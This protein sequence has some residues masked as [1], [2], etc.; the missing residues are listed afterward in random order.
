MII[1]NKT[2]NELA[3]GLLT[4]WTN[5]PRIVTS[6]VYNNSVAFS[7]FLNTTVINKVNNIFF[8]SL[9]RLLTSIEVI[10]DFVST[11]ALQIKNSVSK[12]FFETP[13]KDLCAIY[14]KAHGQTKEELRIVYNLK[15]IVKLDPSKGTL[16][17]RIKD[18]NVDELLEIRDQKNTLPAPL[19]PKA[20]ENPINSARVK[21]FS[22]KENSAKGLSELE[23]FLK[24]SRN[25]TLHQMPKL[26]IIQELIQ[27]NEEKIKVIYAR[28]KKF[29]V[30]LAPL[31][32]LSTNHEEA[33]KKDLQ[34]CRV[35][36]LEKSFT[37]PSNLVK[38][39]PAELSN[40]IQQTKALIENSLKKGKP[41][42]ERKI[43]IN[44]FQRNLHKLQ[45]LV[46]E[47]QVVQIDEEKL[48]QLTTVYTNYIKSHKGFLQK[49]SNH[50]TSSIENYI[51]KQ[52]PKLTN[53]LAEVE[54]NLS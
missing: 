19:S 2:T 53:C 24:K 26:T 9:Q 23:S 22:L 34:D 7:E 42:S 30:N 28:L 48:T 44:H 11:K 25:P 51:R 39:D 40:M 14:K 27:K 5:N 46:T 18:Y 29:V 49:A 32:P 1:D 41:D 52:S 13:K 54:Y 33:L 31:P 15:K 47:K 36:W 6:S 10:R 17:L 50:K 20:S 37:K 43:L 8:T 35:N 3:S 16:L 38:I 21:K 4:V 12:Y 45:D